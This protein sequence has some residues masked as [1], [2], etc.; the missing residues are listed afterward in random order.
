MPRSHFET[1]LRAS[2]CVKREQHS[3]EER[4]AVK[5]KKGGDPIRE[6]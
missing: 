3:W 1:S 4:S 5:D 2:V 6:R